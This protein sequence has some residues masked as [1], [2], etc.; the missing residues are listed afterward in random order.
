MKP[1]GVVAVEAHGVWKRYVG[2]GWV[3][4][5][6]ELAIAPSMGAIIIG[7]NGSGKT[8]FLKIVSGLIRPSR[9]R[10]RVYGLAPTSLEAK[11]LMGVVL[12]YSLLYDE[13][14]VRE[15]LEYY[16]KLYGVE[17]FDVESYEVAEILGLKNYLGRRVGELSFGWRK[18][19]DIA[20]ALLHNP[21]LLVID[22]PFTGLDDAATQA[23]SELLTEKRRR[24]L[25]IL[26]TSPQE[27][28]VD[29]LPAFLAYRLVDGRLKLLRET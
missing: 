17:D 21:K 18:R 20:R 12:H 29:L 3:L 25:A 14:T 19:A 6:V 1:H 15:N 10:V 8:T 23:L 5:G 22:E 2:S 28:V 13:F 11:R 4:R 26:A 9:G 16:A 7:A 27:H 24:G